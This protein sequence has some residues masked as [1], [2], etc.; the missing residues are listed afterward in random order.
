MKTYR[1]LSKNCIVKIANEVNK[2]R[3]GLLVKDYNTELYEVVSIPDELPDWCD[4]LKVGSKFYAWKNWK[5]FPVHTDIE[6]RETLW[7][8]DLL[9]IACIVE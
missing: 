7:C 4:G 6:T 5:G 1:P 9:D 2:T 8:I 3:S